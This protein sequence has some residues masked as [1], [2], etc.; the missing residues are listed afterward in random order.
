MAAADGLGG[1]RVVFSSCVVNAAH[2][3][4]QQEAEAAPRPRQ[5]THPRQRLSP[6]HSP[7]TPV[8]MSLNSL[9]IKGSLALPSR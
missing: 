1:T 6:A 7:L 5:A 3:R 4:A 2:N 8:T 9:P